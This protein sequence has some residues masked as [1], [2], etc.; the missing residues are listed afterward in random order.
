[1]NTIKQLLVIT[2]ATVTQFVMHCYCLVKIPRFKYPFD[3]AHTYAQICKPCI[4]KCNSSVQYTYA[5]I[6]GR[7]Y[8]RVEL[9]IVQG[10]IV[11]AAYVTRRSVLSLQ[12]LHFLH[13]SPSRGNLVTIWRCSC[14][15]PDR[16]ECLIEAT[17]IFSVLRTCIYT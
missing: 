5:S 7:S 17:S 13:L 3:R 9:I 4:Y 2:T 8:S 1:M 11:Q 6:H 12:S 15:G 16:F 10:R 14:T